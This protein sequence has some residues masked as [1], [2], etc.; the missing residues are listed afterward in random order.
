[1][2]EARRIKRIFD[3][4]FAT[5]L[6]FAAA[7]VAAVAAIAIW[8][9]SGGPIFFGHNRI[10]RGNRTFRLWKFRTMRTDGDAILA[11]HLE[12]DPEAAAEWAETRKFRNDPRVTQV[13]R[14]LRRTSLDELPQLWNVLRGDM[15]LAG[16]R[17]VVEAEIEH[18]GASWP[19]YTLALPGLTGLWQ[20]SG[21]SD[22]T[23]RRRVELDSAYVRNWTMGMDLMLLLRTVRVVIKGKGAY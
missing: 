6:V 17:P 12:A 11:A 10:G 13:G 7:P 4:F 19:L 15:S 18:Y 8:L 2:P 9:E 3:I 20:V 21:R 1:M 5:L 23:Y 22:T 16:P 14:F